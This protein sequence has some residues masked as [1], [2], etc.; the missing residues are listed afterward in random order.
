ME[1]VNRYG[2]AL[3]LVEDPRL[4]E[5]YENYHKAIW[6]EI[7]QSIL[8]SGIT[9]M[10]IY[11]FHNRLFMIIETVPGFSFEEKNRAD[12]ANLK[13]QEWEQLMW[14]YQQAVPAARPGEKW[15]LMERIFKL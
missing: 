3:D 4:I 12:R 9:A 7:K 2:L 15:V 1:P 14:K 6:P 10:E 11:R 13:V 8:D 5:E